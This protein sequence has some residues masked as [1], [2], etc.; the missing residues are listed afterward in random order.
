MNFTS[1]REL[2]LSL[3][4]VLCQPVFSAPVSLS[5]LRVGTISIRQSEAS[6]VQGLGEPDYRAVTGYGLVLSY[7]DLAVGM[8]S[9]GGRVR[10]LETS[11]RRQCLPSKVCP[12]TPISGAI[13]AYGR[14]TEDRR[15]DP[16]N[17]SDE[18]GMRYIK[19]LT[20]DKKCSL[21]QRRCAS[22][23]SS[24]ASGRATPHRRRPGP[25]RNPP[26]P[27]PPS[28]GPPRHPHP[29][30]LSRYVWRPGGESQRISNQKPWRGCEVLWWQ[31]ASIWC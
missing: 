4:F 17:S 13:H 30:P 18:T 6:V 1:S 22:K 5:D 28:P 14:P 29:V 8:T 20:Q 24:A 2:A 12:K 11:S 3:I 26:N 23:N 25:G 7:P 27:T 16:K 15:G 10:Q 31:F 21:P 19:Y 9:S